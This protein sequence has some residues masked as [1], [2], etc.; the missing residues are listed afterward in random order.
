MRAARSWLALL[1]ACITVLAWLPAAQARPV[2]VPPMQ[3]RVVDL[4]NTLPASDAEA[5]RQQIATLESDTQAQL[6][7]LVVPTTGEDSIEQYATRV[8]AD[9][10]LGREAQD[11]GVLLLVALKDRRMR[12]EVGTGLEGTITDLQAGRII[13]QQ[14]TPRFRSGDFAGGIQ[15]AVQSLAQLIG[16]GDPSAAQ[17]ISQAETPQVQSLAPSEDDA[18]H[19]TGGVMPAGW[20]LFG[21]LLWS[22]GVGVWHARQTLKRER[23][24][25]S[26]GKK[27]RRLDIAAPAPASRWPRTSAMLAAAPLV[28][29]VALRDPA[30]LVMLPTLAVPLGFGLGIACTRWKMART[31]AAAA[32][33]LIVALVIA[34]KVLGPAEV[35]LGVMYTFLAAI[36]LGFVSAIAFG[37]RNAWRAGALNFT[38]RLLFVLGAM[39]IMGFTFDQTAEAGELWIPLA[40]VAAL[41]AAFAFFP[42]A[43]GGGGGGGSSGSSWS[44]SSSSGGSSSS[45]SSSSSGGGGSSSGGGAS[46]SW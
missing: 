6:A 34:A 4:T 18:S 24:A 10:K 16:G 20:A 17:Q 41:S 43:F 29:T 32:L 37:M 31:I 26:S 27:K 45:S 15:A 8:F 13:D 30:L 12:I 33:L 36:A 2:A 1:L 22:I 40:L 44:S 38:L 46:G 21:V 9:W 5:L 25:P 39:A 35:G 19:G 42:M 11:D 14:M 23:A 28:A 3:S 7:I